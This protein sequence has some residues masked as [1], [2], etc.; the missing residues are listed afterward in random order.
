METICR[1]CGIEFTDKKSKRGFKNQC[2]DCSESDKT[3]RALGF[4]DGSV[5]KGVA[6]QVYIGSDPRVRARIQNQK[7]RTGI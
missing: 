5:N 4:N 1:D 2:D 6:I 3:L 7:A